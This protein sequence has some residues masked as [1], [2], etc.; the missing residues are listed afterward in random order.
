M[1]IGSHKGA[2]DDGYV[3]SSRLLME[4]YLLRPK[5]FS[6]EI[7]AEGS[8]KDMRSLEAEML[9]DIDARKNPTY[10]NQHNGNG[11]FYNK[12]HTEDTK[13]KMSESRRGKKRKP[14]SEEHR[15]KQS[16]ANTGIIRSEETKKK[17]SK[18]GKGK[19]KSEEH[20]RKISEANKGK[21]RS[22][23]TKRKMSES[24]KLYWLKRKN[25]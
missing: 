12:G 14:F 21:I 19:S 9:N 6:R 5:D 18:A 20:R 4:Q 11:D 8:F 15:R 25:V 16:E 2:I 23:D 17:L 1:Y 7:V 10:Y 24:I 13:R 22:E 3:C